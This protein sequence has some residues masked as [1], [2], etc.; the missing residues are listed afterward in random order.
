MLEAEEAAIGVQK[1]EISI[2][3]HMMCVCVCFACVSACVCRNS[4]GIYIK[5]AKLTTG[6][7][8]HKKKK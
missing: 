8:N 1:K 2:M 5:L 6:K 3:E 4:H 7:S